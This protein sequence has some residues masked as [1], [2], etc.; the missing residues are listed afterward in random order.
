MQS[1]GFVNVDLSLYIIICE[2]NLFIGDTK[3]FSAIPLNDGCFFGA[4]EQQKSIECFGWICSG[5]RDDVTKYKTEYEKVCV[6]VNSLV[7]ENTRTKA[8]QIIC[9]EECMAPDFRYIIDPR[10]FLIK[11]N[12][13]G[14]SNGTFDSGYGDYGENQ[15]ATHHR[16][17]E[18]DRVRASQCVREREREKVAS[19]MRTSRI[20]T[21]GVI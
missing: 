10:F 7:L 5:Q 4:L 19:R 12:W 18:R 14:Y 11:I 13:L 16:E 3:L 17:I 6:C 1:G 20:W 21:K 2:R 9:Y 8:A 15:A